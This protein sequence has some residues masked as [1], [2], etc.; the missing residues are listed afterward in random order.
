MAFHSN[1]SP[2]HSF[3]KKPWVLPVTAGG[4]AALA[5][6]GLVFMGMKKNPAP[7]VDSSSSAASSW[8]EPEEDKNYTMDNKVDATQFQGT[9][10]PETEDAGQSYLDETLFIGDSNTARYM[11]YGPEDSSEPFTTIDNNIGVVSMG[12]Q[13]IES[14]ACQ[15][16]KGYSSAV[17][18]P[19]AVEIMQPRRIII[20][21]GTNNL[22]MNVEQYIRNYKEGLEAIR[23]A[24]PHAEII[25][26]AVPP[27]DKQRSNTSLTMQKVD[28]FNSALVTMCKE[29]GYRFLDSSEALEDPSSGWA[30]KD[31]TLSD[32][33]H[34]SQT[35]VRALFHYIRTHASTTEDTRPKP[36]KEIPAVKGVTPNL[37]DKDP[38]AVRGEQDGE[39]DEDE[40]TTK[41]VP[42]EFTAGEGGTIVGKTSQ[43]VEVGG[44]C[45]PVVAQ[46]DEGWEFDYWTA[47]IGSTGTSKEKLTFKVP[48]NADANGVIL[49]A[50][51]K[52]V[53]A[54]SEPD[55]SEV[56]S[57]ATPKPTA[58]PEPVATAT[59]APTTAPTREPVAT[60]TPAPVA[61]AAPAVTPAPTKEPTPQPT[62]TTAPTPAPT[63]EPTAAPTPAP[64]P[65]PTPAPA[66]EP[67][68]V[69]SSVE[70][71]Q[72]E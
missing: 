59:P 39:D 35:G 5:V 7:L 44:S 18:I 49:K 19:K 8:V 50:H 65:E 14:L 53:E 55:S 31:Y 21:F 36:L 15:N 32:G 22:G 4:V 60:A 41:K 63:P 51:F 30:K 69:E 26:N 68:V 45:S 56:E 24:Y 64:T 16:F 42:V 40:S 29:E 2:F 66:P 72:P 6:V 28:A 33:V 52:K 17:T 1:Q 12:V 23:E 3:L 11:V 58:T 34:L 37:I 46:P 67:P 62:A 25:V 54:E 43:L 38:I 9:V 20:G 10:L 13:Q 71:A 47:T 27:V 57:T 61:T 48:G 70:S